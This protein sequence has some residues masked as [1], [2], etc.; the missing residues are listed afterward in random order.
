MSKQ[1]YFLVSGNSKTNL[2]INTVSIFGN[3]CP[4]ITFHLKS[5][6]CRLIYHQNH[7]WHS[8]D[9]FEHVLKISQISLNFTFWKSIFLDIFCR[10][11]YMAVVIIVNPNMISSIPSQKYVIFMY[12]KSKSLVLCTQQCFFITAL[13]I[14]YSFP[15]IWSW[16]AK[17]R[18]GNEI[19]FHFS[20]EMI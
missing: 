3:F 9:K 19:L 14:N 5:S 10:D 1:S 17:K 2:S 16:K 11:L 7:H 18:M 4:K 12:K 6:R 20:F 15:F 8:Q 13:I